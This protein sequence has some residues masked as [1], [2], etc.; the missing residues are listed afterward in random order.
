MI[1]QFFYLVDHFL[2]W[3]V[4]QQISGSYCE[5]AHSYLW[6]YVRGCTVEDVRNTYVYL[7]MC[8][9]SCVRSCVC[10]CVCVYV[11]V[12]TRACLVRA[13]ARGHARAL[14]RDFHT[15]LFK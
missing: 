13:Y 4:M 14:V 12:R 9:H 1:W 8:A 3:L 7:Y 6:T 11:C 2:F 5:L 15:Y 10:V